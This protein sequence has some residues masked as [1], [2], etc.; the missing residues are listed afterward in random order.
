MEKYVI[1]NDYSST[2][3]IIKWLFEILREFDQ[4]MKAKFL[5]YTLG[6]IL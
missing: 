3:N 5:F 1:S 4:S 6:L 2:S